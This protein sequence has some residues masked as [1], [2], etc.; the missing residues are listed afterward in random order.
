MNVIVK[1][2][3]GE[4]HGNKVTGGPVA[5]SD[6]TQHAAKMTEPLDL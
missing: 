3:L 1:D 2:K 5:L 4:I 6:F